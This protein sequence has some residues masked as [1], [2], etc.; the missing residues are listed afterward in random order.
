MIVV[1]SR[2]KD[3][4]ITTQDFK[5]TSRFVGG[6]RGSPRRISNEEGAFFCACLLAV[7]SSSCGQFQLQV[8]QQLRLIVQ[9]GAFLAQLLVSA[10]SLL[11]DAS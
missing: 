4:Q 6:S 5:L 9:I 2:A 8:R 1:S 11:A 10:S 7:T 3:A